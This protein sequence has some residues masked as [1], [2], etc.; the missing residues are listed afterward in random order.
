MNDLTPVKIYSGPRSDY[1]LVWF[2]GPNLWFI[3]CTE[4]AS[5][6]QSYSS[7]GYDSKHAGMQAFEN[8]TITYVDRAPGGA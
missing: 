6:E 3:R 8:S 5:G 4:R 2:D 1:E 7:E